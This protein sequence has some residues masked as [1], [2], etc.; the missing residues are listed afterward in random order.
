MDWPSFYPADCPPDSSEPAD[1]TV[2]RLI[3]GSSP[4]ASDFRSF[5]ELN[6]TGHFPH[7]PE[8]E[9]CG[10]SVFTNRDD[11]ERIKRRVPSKRNHKVSCGNLSHELGRIK[12][13][14][15]EDNSHHTWWPPN[16]TE[17]WRHFRLI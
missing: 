14:P 2:Y 5:R 17:P 10:L 8:C 3:A 13:T 6:P 4:V 9:V 12:A 7:L 11:I 1:G 15:R 16:S